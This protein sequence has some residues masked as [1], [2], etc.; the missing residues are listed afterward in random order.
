MN[1]V[2]ATQVMII[3]GKPTFIHSLVV[4]GRGPRSLIATV[5]TLADEPIGVALPPKPAPIAK[6]QNSGAISTSGLLSPMLMITGIIAAVKGM[7]SMRALANADTQ[8]T[9]TVN[10]T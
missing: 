9:A 7:L 8:T 2:A 6:A 1:I 10:R 4:I 3:I 5:I